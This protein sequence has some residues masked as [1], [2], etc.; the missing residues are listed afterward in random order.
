MKDLGIKVNTPT[1]VQWVNLLETEEQNLI[2]HKINTEIAE[3][4]IKLA[5]KRIE[6]EKEKL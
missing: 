2:I 6:E 3:L 4:K 1:G 5:K